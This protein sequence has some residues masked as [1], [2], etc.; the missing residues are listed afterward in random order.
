M[1]R[2]APRLLEHWSAAGRLD[3]MNAAVSNTTKRVRSS[4]L[5]HATVRIANRSK[6][7]CK[8][9]S[10]ADRDQAHMRQQITCKRHQSGRAPSVRV[11]DRHCTVPSRQVE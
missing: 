4:L 5:M 1:W 2:F 11:V 10:G 3:A 9:A 6:V 7:L 8:A